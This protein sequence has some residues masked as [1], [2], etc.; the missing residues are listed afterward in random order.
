M[1]TQKVCS[2]NTNP[3]SPWA[4]A[5]YRWAKQLAICYGT[6]NAYT[7]QDPPMPPV[8]Q[9]T[10]PDWV[11]TF[12]QDEENDRKCLQTLIWE[13]KQKRRICPLYASQPR[14]KILLPE[15][16]PRLLR[17][18]KARADWDET[19]P[20]TKIGVTMKNNRDFE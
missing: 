1:P 11:S 6:I 8:P 15:Y 19:H 9:G 7:F 12:L 20:K 4:R 18:I 2:G 14:L 17:C 10:N 13:D 5:S 16:D 3:Y